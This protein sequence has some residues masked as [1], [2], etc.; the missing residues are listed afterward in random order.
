MPTKFEVA[1]LY[2]ATFN[3]AADSA[4]L[5][6]WVNDSNLPIEGIAQSFFDQPETQQKYPDYISNEVFVNTIYQNLFNRDAKEAGLDYWVGELE[7]GNISRGNMI[8]AIINGALGT[9]R[10]I[11]EH[12]TAVSIYYADNDLNDIQSAYSVLDGVDYTTDSVLNSKQKIDNLDTNHI[13]GLGELPNANMYEVKA[14]DSHTQWDKDTITYSFNE[15]IPYDYYELNDPDIIDGWQP[16]NSSDREAVREIFGKLEEFLDVKFQEVSDEG[17]IRFNKVDMPYSA[18]FSYFPEDDTPISGDVFL[19]ND[20]DAQ[21]NEPGTYGYMTIVHEIGHALGLEHPFDGDSYLPQDEDNML[22][23]IM[24]YTEKQDGVVDI[25]CNSYEGRYKYSADASPDNYQLYDVMALQTKYGINADTNS[26]SDRYDLSSL[27]SEKG[28]IVLWDSDGMDT[29]DLSDTKYKDVI[30]LEDATLSSVDIHNTNTQINKWVKECVSNGWSKDEARD[31][32][33]SI[34]SNS[35]IQETLY[36]GHNNLEIA[37][38]VIIENVITGNG[39]DIVYDNS[40]DNFI[41]TGKGNDIIYLQ[42][43]GYDIVDAGDGKDS[44]YLSF[45]ESEANIYDITNSHMIIESTDGETVVELIGVE[46][47]YFA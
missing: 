16:L 30:R 20:Y 37:K 46:N 13:N 8:L 38:G 27:Y 7:S 12:K 35:Y 29:I 10:L 33:E 4:G 41:S 18:G 32:I 44:V 23:T 3:R 34:Y 28:H 26:S 11:L 39:N 6:Y 25:D 19:A 31:W 15:Y 47:I 42:D 9:D 40:Q 1:R 24:T 36:T 45:R 17:D 14:I 5:D 21:G 22:Y 43:G 2:T